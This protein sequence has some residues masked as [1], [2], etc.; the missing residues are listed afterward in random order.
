MR[1]FVGKEISL[2]DKVV[3]IAPKYRSLVIGTVIKF[4]PT[5]LKISYRNTWNVPTGWDLEILQKPNQVV[6]VS[7]V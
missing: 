1:D 7:D 6:K 4:T 2:G 5:A 3:M